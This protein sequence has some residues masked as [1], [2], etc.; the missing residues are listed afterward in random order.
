MLSSSHN[1]VYLDYTSFRRLHCRRATTVP[2]RAVVYAHQE[3][4]YAIVTAVG[5]S[6][7]SDQ[8]SRQRRMPARVRAR[9]RSS[10]DP[11][12]PERLRSEPS[13]MS[14]DNTHLAVLS[15]FFSR[16]SHCSLQSL[17]LFSRYFLTVLELFPCSSMI[18]KFKARTKCYRSFGP[19]SACFRSSSSK[20]KTRRDKKNSLTPWRNL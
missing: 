1:Y 10:S 16:F 4:F 3:G 8:Q 18:F 11:A 19:R 14:T 13:S 9:L 5:E 7:K 20:K 12:F 6:N 15:R 17:S 2:R